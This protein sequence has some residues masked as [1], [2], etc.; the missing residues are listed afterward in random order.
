MGRILLQSLLAILAGNA[1]YFLAL[2]PHVPARWQHQP[3]KLDAGLL[4]D[5]ALCAALY[6]LLR[7]VWRPPSRRKLGVS[8]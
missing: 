1:V 6:L 5:F 3:A 8:P 7:A 2:Y 4:V